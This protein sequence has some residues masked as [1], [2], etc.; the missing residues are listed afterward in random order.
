MKIAMTH[1][2]LPNESKGGVAHQ[3][4]SLANV[5]AERGHEVTMFTFSP[6]YAECRYR[7]HQ[8]STRRLP[9]NPSWRTFLFAARLARTDFSRF[10]VLHTNGDNYLLRGRHPQVRTFY[11][12]AKDEFLSAV[13][14]RRRL[15]QAFMVTLEEIGG[16]V[17]DVNVGISE[18]TRARIPQVTRII[19]CGVDTSRFRPGPK[20]EKPAILFVGTTGGRKRGTFLADVFAREVRPRFPSAELWA[21]TE[22][23]L[24]G[25]GIQNFGRASTDVLA[26]LYQR[27]W[28]FCLPSTYEGFGVPYIEALA[29]GTAVVA[30]PNPGAKEVLCDSRF[31]LIA[32]DE[33]I[34]S[35]LNSLLSE[36][37]ARERYAAHGL[38]RAQDFRWE[39][40]AEQYEKVYAELSGKG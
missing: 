1:V 26:D 4:H 38:L 30:S 36:D 10:D 18:A 28:V 5:L 35:A 8:Y 40:V 27:A 21:V 9:R 33:G 20:A 22:R 29:A 6:P 25:E 3:V 14:L 23:P 13:R 32:N 31:G 34:G 11:G 17:A 16:R 7:V 19:P 15:Y 2:A 24:P 37:A 12:S 39:N